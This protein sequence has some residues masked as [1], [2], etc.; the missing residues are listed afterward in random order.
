MAVSLAK[1]DVAPRADFKRGDFGPAV[2]VVNVS[3]D[4][5]RTP[6]AKAR[7]MSHRTARKVKIAQAMAALFIETVFPA[8][9]DA[10]APRTAR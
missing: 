8:P 3:R 6:A 2:C 9:R 5:T 10:F 1:P 4:R 7:T